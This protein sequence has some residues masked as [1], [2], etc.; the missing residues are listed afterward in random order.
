MIHR[1]REGGI[2]RP[3]INWNWTGRW[4]DLRFLTKFGDRGMGL[5]F[6]V[7]LGSPAYIGQKRF[8]YNAKTWSYTE[9]DRLM[10]GLF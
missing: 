2:S 5:H 7:R 8:D 3:G 4:F 6:G 10:R 1:V 9:Q